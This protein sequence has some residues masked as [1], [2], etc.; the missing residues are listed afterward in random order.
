MKQLRY[1]CDL[2]KCSHPNQCSQVCTENQSD[3]NQ[4]LNV[5]RLECGVTHIFHI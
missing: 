1:N 3:L 2:K 4:L 5:S